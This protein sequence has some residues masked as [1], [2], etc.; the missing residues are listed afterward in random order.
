MKVKDSVRVLAESLF[1]WIPS[2]TETGLRFL[3]ILMRIVRSF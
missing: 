2:S 3:E 1:R